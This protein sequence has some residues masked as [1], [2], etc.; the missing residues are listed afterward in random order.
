MKRV[1]LL[2]VQQRP[3][4]YST[5]YREVGW[6]DAIFLAS[7]SMMASM[8]SVRVP[9]PTEVYVRSYLGLTPRYKS[10]LSHI[11]ISSTQ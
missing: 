7:P 6:T 11:Y 5:N 10:A 9:C 8:S 1:G 3:A 4:V 2:C